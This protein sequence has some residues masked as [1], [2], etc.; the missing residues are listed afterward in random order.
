MKAKY[1][2]P[3]IV[4]CRGTPTESKKKYEDLVNDHKH[5]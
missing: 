1:S 2:F 3:F 4:L 5:K